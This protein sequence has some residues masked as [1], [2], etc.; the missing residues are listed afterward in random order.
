VLIR[1]FR[2]R[3][4][5]RATP[6]AIVP[7]FYLIH[8]VAALA[9][10][11][12]V[13]TISM[14]VS[15]LAR[16]KEYYTTVLDFALVDEREEAGEAT[17]RLTGVFASRTRTARLRLGE[18][19][20]ELV[21][22]LAPRGRAIPS[23]S[24]SND[25]WFQ[26]IAIAV[27]DIDRAYARLREHNARHASPGPQTLPAW[28]LNAA[29]ITAFYFLDP[30][31]HVLEIIHFPAG[32]GDERWHPSTS[33]PTFER[34]FLGIDHTAIVIG[35]TERS[36]AFYRDRLGLT[37]VG[38]SENYGPEQERLNGVFGARLRITT[39]RAARGPGVELLEY[40][41]PTTG[42]EYPVDSHTNDLW[43]WHTSFVAPDLAALKGALGAPR[44]SA[45]SPPGDGTEG[46]EL[47]RDPDGHAV[48]LTAPGADGASR[49]RVGSAAPARI[50]SVR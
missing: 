12:A 22:F 15:D 45:S 17:E 11:S 3:R 44:I 26:H 14:T 20:I 39:L 2:A 28:N 34:L 41:A 21:E 49:P 29:G 48:R 40:L 5:R 25:R 30:D 36:L 10:T 37:V 18:E 4:S 13:S 24:R 43:H 6:W 7:L 42:R 27:S 47:V 8:C 33:T 35:D 31:G 50:H 19:T 1:F 32:K 16:S 23:D 9:Q 46:P 38:A